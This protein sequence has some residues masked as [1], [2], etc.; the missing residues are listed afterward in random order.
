MKSLD[1]SYLRYIYDGIFKGEISSEN[2]SALPEGLVG[3]YEVNFQ[4]NIPLAK[5]QQNLEI[6]TCW[7][8]LKKEVSVS[9]VSEL[10]ELE[11][12]AL[13]EFVS[14]YAFWFNSPESGKYSLYHER[15][16][17]YFLQKLGEKEVQRINQRI[18]NRLQKAI[19]DQQKDEFEIYALQFLS[20]HLIV[21]AFADEAKGKEL[22]A[23]TKNESN[24]NRQIKVSNEFNWTKN[25]IQNTILWTAKYQPKESVFGYLDLV[26]LHHKEQNDAENIVSLVT[27][28]EIDLALNRIESFGGTD[29][30]GLQRKFIL[31]MLCLMELTLLE[32]KTQPWRK[33]ALEKILKHF[34]QQ[35]PIDHSILNWNDFF[36]SYLV[37]QMSCEWA[38][39]GLD[40]LIVFKRTD[41]WEKDWLTEKGPYT[42]LQLEVLLVCARG[43]S[44]DRA[45]SS[46]LKVISTELAKQSL[47]EEAFACANAISYESTKSSTFKVISTEL[48]KQGRMDEALAYSHVISDE[49]DKGIAI[50]D[51]STELVKQGRMEEALVCA[52]GISD[53]SN[54]ISAIKC[55]SAELAKQ[56]NM[57]KAIQVAK[58]ISDDLEK[59]K[60]FQVIS[61]ELVELNKIKEAFQIVKLISNESLKYSVYYNISI[62][63]AKNR[64]IDEALQIAQSISDESLQNNAL[65]GIINKLI[66]FGE[67]EKAFKIIQLI[68]NDS[69]K[70][71][72]YNDISIEFAIQ[73]KIN[74]AF[75]LINKIK[76]KDFKNISL[77]NVCIQ[78][79][80]NGL[81]KVALEYARGI[82][83]ELY[84]CKSLC[85]ISSN[86]YKKN[87]IEEAENVIQ[88]AI[89]NALLI[90][91]SIDK[92]MA[93][94]EISKELV[95][96]EKLEQ[97]LECARHII[98]DRERDRTIIIIYKVFES[99][100][101]DGIISDPYK[102][103]RS[104]S[105]KIDKNNISFRITTLLVE[106]NS[107]QEAKALINKCLCFERNSLNLVHLNILITKLSQQNMS[108]YVYKCIREIKNDKD[109]FDKL[110][111]LSHI[112]IKQSKIDEAFK[113]VDNVKDLEYRDLGLFGV[114]DGLAK[115]KKFEE[116]L[117][118]LDLI[119]S[120]HYKS[121]AFIALSSAQFK[122]GNF[123][124]AEISIYKSIEIAKKII[125]NR[126]MSLLDISSEFSKRGYYF[127]AKT[128]AN[129]MS[130][131]LDKIKALLIIYKDLAC[132][133]NI[134]NAELNLLES[135]SCAKL[136]N[137]DLDKISGLLE[138][139]VEIV[140]NGNLQKAKLVL[141]ECLSIALMI[142]DE[143][144]RDSA[145]SNV[146]V[147]LAEQGMFKESIEC[148]RNINEDIFKY[149][150]ISSIS[151]ELV[152][153]G[154]L[155]ES[156]KNVKSI[157][158]NYFKFVT[159]SQIAEE[160][161]K[162]GKIE[163]ALEC[164]EDI[165][166][167]SQKSNS[168]ESIS[169]E[170]A[171]HKKWSLS[172]SISLEITLVEKF[173]SCWKEIA[174]N[175]IEE[176]GATLAFETLSH[177][178]NEE[179]RK[180][181]LKG[182][183]ENVTINDLNEDILLQALPFL[184]DDSESIEHLLQTHAINEL[185]FGE[186]STDE[187]HKYNRTLN[188]QWAMDIKA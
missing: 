42:S 123:K 156:L 149:T 8:L 164:C 68:N 134:D 61:I 120:K 22:L 187:I 3:M 25:T 184:K 140:K 26:E 151:I 141:D 157:D 57:E 20:D 2:E 96:Q 176:K 5:R 178:Q 9:F 181:Y 143:I 130:N 183:A 160:L 174:K 144:D 132:K 165:Y 27:N 51:I 71:R 15:L 10:L 145:F 171:R 38:E 182:W 70:Y 148:L 124:E 32:S 91:S 56:G 111:E 53:E 154:L 65:K 54:K 85:Y 28:N 43:I 180:Y 152:K 125:L 128:C 14:T 131:S 169:I 110:I 159:L 50:A 33:E 18:I 114:C 73:G 17:I 177:L 100:V 16:R 186:L 40:C 89:D 153:K 109:K 78:I 137:D 19:S 69:Y 167:D 58:L 168:L 98:D 94:R 108:Q 158:E 133:G 172:E 49:S 106:K 62:Q 87:R 117:K 99:L 67:I 116:S 185:F 95:K 118:Y 138:I 83:F 119:S 86:F 60:A 146:S 136:I 173:Q 7:A 23:F 161:A 6:F 112:L 81:E 122:F 11:E 64:D 126:S 52:R 105:S 48:A 93:L 36:P 63:L 66:E 44:D 59:C 21:E 101:K 127:E 162:Q 175:Q 39:L 88:E 103:I 166:E 74:E 41:E 34:D 45:K 155:K 72:A 121:K 4:E 97:A 188:I 31:Y 55:I 107:I 77:M 47:M 170:L 13:V 147:V 46:A 129:Y 37:F 113:I 79:S 102:C 142:S 29:Q 104:I 150:P 92:P 135:I 75:E 84:K 82:Y 76:S 80:N 30:E 35:M 90:K 163:E 139:F 179:V 12:T 24:W 115:Q 1:P